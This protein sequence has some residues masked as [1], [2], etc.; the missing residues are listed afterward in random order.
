MYIR[1]MK[2]SLYKGSLETIIVHLL[3]DGKMYGYQI[4]QKIKAITDGE[5][6]VKEGSLYP[7]LHKMEAKGTIT[8]TTEKYENRLRKYYHL[9]PTGSKIK[10]ELIAEMKSYLGLMDKILDTQVK[11]NNR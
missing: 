11:L 1:I 3:S 5:I 6:I 8:A 7:L 2:S 10:N 9:T 4:T